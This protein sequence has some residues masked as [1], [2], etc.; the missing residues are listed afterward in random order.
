M[1]YDDR[2]V[3][4]VAC[5]L[6]YLWWYGGGEK[7][8]QCVGAYLR[9]YGEHLRLKAEFKKAVC[10]VERT[11]RIRAAFALSRAMRRPGVATYRCARSY[12]ASRHSE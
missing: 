10:V 3:Q 9:Q 1:R 12:T 11:A 4:H 2:F 5:Q 6:P 8:A 7:H